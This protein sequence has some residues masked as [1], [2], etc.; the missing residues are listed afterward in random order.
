M[1]FVNIVFPFINTLSVP[2]CTLVNQLENLNIDTTFLLN[3][4][5]DPHI[6]LKM[7]VKILDFKEITWLTD[8][9]NPK[10]LIF[11]FWSPLKIS[12]KEKREWL[13]AYSK[14]QKPNNSFRITED[15]IR[16]FFSSHW[17]QLAPWLFRHFENVHLSPYYP[18]RLQFHSIQIIRWNYWLWVVP[19]P[20]IPHQLATEIHHLC[21]HSDK[22]QHYS[23][24]ISWNKETLC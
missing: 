15:P 1:R 7:Y 2:L 3:S 5:E 10:E 18:T 4:E 16:F 24:Y 20:Q 9:T 22:A 8:K 14:E 12:T 6:C 23:N 19:Q 13:H 11:F 21:Y 17:A